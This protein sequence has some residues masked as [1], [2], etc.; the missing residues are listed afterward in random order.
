MKNQQNYL[1][2]LKAALFATLDDHTKMFLNIA[3]V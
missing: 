1:H 3:E 2:K